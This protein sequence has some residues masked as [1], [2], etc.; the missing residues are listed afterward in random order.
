MKDIVKVVIAGDICP[1]KSST[2]QPGSEIY[3]NPFEHI[4]AQFQNADY[5]VANLECPLTINPQPINK[6]GPCLWADPAFIPFIKQSGI[7]ALGLA[8]N[9]IRDAGSRGV[10]DTIAGCN[11]QGISTFGAGKDLVES[12]HAHIAEI[13]GVRI[14]FLAMAEHEFCIADTNLPG[15]NPL[16]SKRFVRFCRKNRD[17][18][19]VL[20][21]L[22]HGGM[23]QYPLPTPEQ[24][25]LCRFMVEEGASVVVCQHSHCIGCAEKYREGHI[26]YGQG[27]FF[28]PYDKP[29]PQSWYT[30]ILVEVSIETHTKNCGIRFIPF[31]QAKDG[32]GLHVVDE[33]GQKKMMT[34]FQERSQQV[35]DANWVKKQWQIQCEQTGKAHM[36]GLLGVKRIQRHIYRYFPFLDS[37]SKTRRQLCALNMI[38]C[39]T[40]REKIQTYLESLSSF[41]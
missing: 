41:K 5:V 7:H 25:D 38:R 11:E 28:F 12:E 16:S 26:V 8:N 34:L 36:W 33:A 31:E 2:N 23:E 20:I 30:G 10:M 6:T 17:R 29:R 21:V 9:H 32:Q 22:Y 15:A 14:C 3:P 4:S 1:A 37:M 19:D 40:H 35:Q 18:Y 24:Q 39:Q 27:N 13:D